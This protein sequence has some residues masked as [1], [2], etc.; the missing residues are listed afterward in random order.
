MY[1]CII[2]KILNNEIKYRQLLKFSQLRGL[3]RRTM[4]N[5]VR[6]RGYFLSSIRTIFETN[7]CDI[8]ILAVETRTLDI[9]NGLSVSRNCTTWL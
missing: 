1:V 9:F 2:L 7:I 4:S 3:S 8:V 6:P 5:I